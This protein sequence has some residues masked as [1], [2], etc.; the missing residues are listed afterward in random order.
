MDLYSL[1]YFQ[2]YFTSAQLG[3]E[4]PAVFR[5]DAV[6]N[7][8]VDL[9]WKPPCEPNGEILEYEISYG[10][11]AELT[12]NSD[13]EKIV[14]DGKRETMKVTGLAMLTSYSFQLRARNSMGY[15]PP[16][17]F[18]AKTKGPAGECSFALPE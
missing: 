10:R 4:P 7:V 11:T 18:L 12:P 1:H 15:G 3:P 8:R 6:Y 9:Y 2:S 16:N 14:V 5:A 13:R 17:E